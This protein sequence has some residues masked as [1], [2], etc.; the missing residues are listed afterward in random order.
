MRENLA[1]SY[2]GYRINTYITVALISGG[3]ASIILAIIFTI[4]MYSTWV[5]VLCWTLGAVLLIWGALA[6]FFELC[7]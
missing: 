7:Q 6:S 2:Y 4:L 3:I 1:K 5:L